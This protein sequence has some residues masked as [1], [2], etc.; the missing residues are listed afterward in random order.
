MGMEQRGHVFV[1]YIDDDDLVREAVSLALR[2][3]FSLVAFGDPRAALEYL[4]ATEV[5][6]VICD[7]DMPELNGTQLYRQLSA[8]HQARFVLFTGAV[9]IDSPSGHLVEK[10]AG[11]DDLRAAVAAVLGEV[12]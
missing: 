6:V 12:A 9:G 4:S 5:D 1:V 11:P 8:R 2:R 7:H 10:P 3:H